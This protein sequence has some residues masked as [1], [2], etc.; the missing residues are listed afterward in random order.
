MQILHR[1]SLPLGG[2]AGL[3][4]KR[5]IKDKKVGGDSS[6]WEGLGNVVYLADANYLPYGETKMHSHSEIDVITVMISGRLTH[7]GSMKDGQSM[8]ANQVQVQRAGGEGFSHNE[9]NPDQGSTRLLQIWALPE[10]AGE[11]AAY[12]LYDLPENQLIRIYGGEKSQSDTFDSH[13]IIDIGLL[14]KGKSVQQQGE[15]LA[16]ITNGEAEIDGVKVVDGD[17]ILGENLQLTVT[18]ENLHLT[19][20]ANA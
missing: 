8:V 10:T 20:V 9:V 1:D 16:Y 5:L 15:Y 12:K 18:S 2:F 6:T 13:T 11:P 3:T 7:E 4:E 14:E 17:L 19:V